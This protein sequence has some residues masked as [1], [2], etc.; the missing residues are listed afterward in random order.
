MRVYNRQEEKEKRQ[1]LRRER[2]A[3]EV[4]LWGRLRGEQ[5]SY[6]FRRQYSVGPYIVDFYCP[7]WKLAI[8]IDGATHEGEEAVVYDANRPAYIESFGIRVL[9]F[10]NQQVYQQ[11]DVVVENIANALRPTR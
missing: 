1:S 4:I 2:P 3:A 11:L 6:K 9:R 8:E 7:H 10:T 5:L